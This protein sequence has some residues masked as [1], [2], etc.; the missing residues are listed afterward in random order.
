M[1][2]YIVSNLKNLIEDVKEQT[3]LNKHLVFFNE[4]LL[5][6]PTRREIVQEFTS[7]RELLS[8]KYK[9]DKQLNTRL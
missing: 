3:A 6:L 9:L 8:K 4:E 5:N 2:K 7:R 1:C